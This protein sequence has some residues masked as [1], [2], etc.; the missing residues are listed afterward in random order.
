MKSAS[1]ISKKIRILLLEDS[2]GD[3]E[4]VERRLINDGLSF[5]IMTVDS[6][7]GFLDGINEFRP[8]V[9]LS[10]LRLPSYDGETALR[11]AREQCPEAPF[12]ILTGAVGEE[13]AV[14]MLHK[15]ATDF[16]L[17]SNLA[18]LDP[19]I[20]RAVKES[21]L[22]RDR[23]LLL[24]TLRDTEDRYRSL[25]ENIP[26]G[27][28]RASIKPPARVLHANLAMAHMVGLDKTEELVSM[29]VK[30]LY[31]DE[32][33]RESFLEEI[34]ARGSAIGREVRLK[35]KDG[36]L[37]WVSV[38]A[39]CHRN[40]AG[41]IDWIEGIME[42]IT[43][44]KRAESET[45]EI[46]RKQREITVL[47][48]SLLAP[49]ALE[50]KLKSITD[51]IVRIFDVDFCRIWLIRHG[52]LCEQGCIHEQEREGPHVCRYRERCL[53]MLASSGRYTHT[54]GE[55]HRRVP[56]GCYKIGLVA[57]DEEHK[58]VTN[59]V[60]NEPRVHNH[61]WA[62]ELGLVS[63]AGYQLRVPGGQTIG[64]L[65]LF[66]RHKIT[67]VEDSMLDGLG[68]TT[69]LI[70]RQAGGEE[71]LRASEE[72]FRG[73]FESS[74][75]A[76]MTVEPPSWTFTSGNPATL[77]MFGLKSVDEFISRTPMDFSPEMQPD[78]RSSA[79]K[80]LEMIEAALREGSKYLEWT[81][82]R[83]DGKE[84][85]ATVLLTRVT[86]TGKTFLQATVRDITEQ[87]K[88]EMRLRRANEEM[89]LLL[90][91]IMSVIIGVS[92]R[93]RITHWNHAAEK[94]FG[95]DAKS[96]VGKLFIECGVDWDW[97]SIYEAISTSI[98][99]DTTVRL[100]NVRYSRR[101]KSEGIL[102][103]TVN[104]LKRENE[105]LEGFMILG[106]D[107]TERRLLEHRLLQ[108]QKLESI[109]QLAAG[110]AHEI[111]SPLQYV[112][113]NLKFIMKSVSMLLGAVM[114]NEDIVNTVKK[115]TD[116]SY[117]SDELPK[118][119]EQSVDGVM[120][121]S[122]I[123]Q[124]MKAFAHPGVGKKIATN[125]NKSIENTTVVSKNEWKYDSD[126]DL[127]LDPNLPP[128]PCFETEFNQVILNLIVNA[129]DAI[130]EAIK[131]GL[132]PRGKIKIATRLEGENVFISVEDNG[133]GIPES[134]RQR[135]FDPFFTT[136][137]VGRGSGQGLAIAHSI[138]VEKHEGDL[139][140]ESESG[141]GA[142]FI[143]RLSA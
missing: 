34:T 135:I 5:D 81:H 69:A 87:K 15:G 37:F 102:G 45:A 110:V 76:I 93:D 75:D 70:I 128:V 78:G 74:R 31:D 60:Q 30:E 101:D 116:L 90:G 3:A 103:L 66:S 104:P 25:V 11:T 64:V 13:R 108:A 8:D 96:V 122:K 134:I 54:D 98:V 132:I 67:P 88:A 26:V 113:D 71:A 39:T 22:I 59:D 23:R 49:A 12:I 94:L 127:S 27:V 95:V 111:N 58:F 107:L 119:I 124:S 125:I 29:P 48:Q 32:H 97:K 47:Q 140:F 89:D 68:S 20:R 2:P 50:K 133:T 40:P 44:R 36:G 86:L 130:K 1:D 100:D 42:N 131:K 123:V 129:V 28:F 138:I 105:I 106:T 137:E 114:S 4:L 142:R 52:D 51:G 126:L 17:K 99:Q 139:Y 85:P 65:A 117:L 115:T 35:R 10:D 83:V 143:I 21:R 38:T 56:F 80:A 62:R 6:A 61:D 73:L 72:M 24:S 141:K 9:I 82:R 91:S 16:I 33:D 92:T 121:V 53:H 63:F 136:K 55:I 79:E 112:G 18:R 84:F 57:S 118:A 41:E 14:D 7:K 43:E 120:R 19:S 109:G 46:L 77:A